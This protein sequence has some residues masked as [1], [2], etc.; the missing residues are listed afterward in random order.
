MMEIPLTRGLVALVDDEDF[1][2]LNEHK[3][4]AHY[5]KGTWYGARHAYS[6]TG[7]NE[8]KR[9]VVELMHRVILKPPSDMECDHINGNGLDNRKANLR[10][11]STRGNQQNQHRIK[12][13][14]Y[15]G[16]EWHK[17]SKRWR[18]KIRYG[19]WQRDLGYYREEVDAAAVYRVAC[20]VL[21]GE[22][23]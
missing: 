18:A 5:G 3:W 19:G 1:E 10:I 21:T 12:S 14:R 17:A 4:Y 22:G 6:G 7:E 9:R 11:V 20:A 23:V 8:H 13:S 15:P 2:K 16:V